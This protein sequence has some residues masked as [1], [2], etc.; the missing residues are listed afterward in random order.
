MI[1]IL[2]EMMK[3]LKHL[4]SRSNGQN[5]IDGVLFYYKEDIKRYKQVSVSQY[6]AVVARWAHNPEVIG[7][8]PITV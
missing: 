7:S 1:Q 5:K 3:N 2:N 4:K 6:G 8:S